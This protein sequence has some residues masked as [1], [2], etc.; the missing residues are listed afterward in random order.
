MADTSPTTRPDTIDCPAGVY[1]RRVQLIAA[2]GAVR[3]GLEDEYHAMRLVLHHDGARVTGIDAGFPRFPVSTCPGATLLLR[4][5][6]GL[7]L[8]TY[9]QRRFA[10][11]DPRQHCTHLYHLALLALAH[12]HRGGMRRYDVAVPSDRKPPVSASLHRDGV[13]VHRWQIEDGAIRA[14]AELAGQ[15]VL[16]GFSRWAAAHFDTEAFEAAMVLHNG[17]F[18]SGAGHQW[19]AIPRS[20]PRVAKFPEMLGA[21]YSYQ[22]VRVE[23]GSYVSGSERDTTSPDTPLLADFD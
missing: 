5:L 13:L 12:A 19:E 9:P 21:C 20:G 15:P 10:T 2:P 18:V 22:P 7:P 14:P 17:I 1:R 6:I 16:Q 4:E 3:A 23:Q 11:I 8:A